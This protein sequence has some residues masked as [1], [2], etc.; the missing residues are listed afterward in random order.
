MGKLT[1]SMAIFHSYVS[2]PEGIRSYTYY[3]DLF[4]THIWE[5]YNQMGQWYLNVPHFRGENG[6]VPSSFRAYPIV[7]I[8]FV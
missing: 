1:I 8:V 3:L 6:N 5:T 2:L 4:G 7:G